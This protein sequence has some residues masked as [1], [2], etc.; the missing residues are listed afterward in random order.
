MYMKKKN[1]V[2]VDKT[3]SFLIVVGALNWGFVAFGM[4]LVEIG[5]GTGLFT[6]IVY[7]LVGLSG[8]WTIFRKPLTGKRFMN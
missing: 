6:D 3:A 1:R 7:G 2:A 5:F 4:N 8:V